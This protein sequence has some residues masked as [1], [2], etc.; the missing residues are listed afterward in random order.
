[1]KPRQ[2]GLG[3]I[4][5][6]HKGSDILWIQYT[7]HGKRYRESSGS[8]DPK[9]AKRLLKQKIS[10]VV[11]NK[12]IG[13]AVEKTTLDDLVAMVEAD[14]KANGRRTLNRALAAA[15]HLREF[16][17]G[18]RKA[19]DITDDTVT[20][21]AAHRLEEKAK[22]STVN[23]E[24]AVL[25]RGFRL[26]RKKVPMIP[27]IKKLK[28]SNVRKG[29][30]EAEQFAAVLRHL[31]DHL[32]P[33]AR[34]AYITGWRRGE[35]LSRM[36]KHVDLKAGWLKLEP[37]ETKNDE[38]REFP[39]T[40]ELRAVLHAQRE[41]VR[42]IEQTTGQIVPWVFCL[43][44]GDRIGNFRKAWATA[45]RLAGVPD[46]LVHD[47]RRTAVR[48]LERAGVPRS[49]AM[50]LTGHKTEAVYRR[51]AIVDKAMLEEGVAKLARLHEA[52]AR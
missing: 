22:P 24:L 46:R 30:F 18:D 47:F 15:A 48:N 14:Y 44:T 17:G 3:T 16:Y 6:H 29:Y 49:A 12:P 39:F 9:V 34:V 13:P 37:G 19:R 31:P 26:G 1:M 7:A 8:P 43:P 11:T 50:K 45:C 4:F 32:K 28:V 36:W 41:W 10:D 27:E 38:G 2:H 52:E 23:C 5:Q 21:Y 25:L 42:K 33:L 20:K 35:L 40:P 51:Y